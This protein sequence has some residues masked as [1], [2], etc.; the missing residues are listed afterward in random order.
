MSTKTVINFNSGPSKLPTP[1][2]ELI[3]QDNHSILEMSHRSKE[4]EALCRGVEKT[5]MRLLE[6]P[7]G[8]R[9]LLLQGGGCGQFAAVP[10]NLG[11]GDYLVTGYWSEKAHQEA[12]LLGRQARMAFFGRPCVQVPR[13]DEIVWD[14]NADYRY[15]CSNET[16]SG[17]QYPSNLLR[18]LSKVVDVP[19]V[20]DA[21]SDLLTRRLPIAE[22]A[23]VFAGA[24]KNLGIA[25]LTV[26]VIRDD[27]LGRIKKGVP[28]VWDYQKQA[29]AKSLLNTPP[30]HAIWVMDKVLDW[31]ESQGGVTAMQTNAERRASLV[32][33]LIDGSDGFYRNKIR[34]RSKVNITFNIRDSAL[35]KTFLQSAEARGF[36]GLEGHRSVGGL[37]ASLYNAIS[38]SETETLVEFM[39][40]FR[41]E[42]N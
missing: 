33:Q 20:I 24:Q 18:D 3:R 10:L 39:E 22:S 29:E 42:N 30:T 28:S 13:V 14:L 11:K 34:D 2:M 5:L 40:K 6:I 4:F 7:D 9:T 31:I 26:V 27:L 35:E 36:S 25:G 38:D 21:S 15:L 32:Y 1:V 23:M 19:L 37:R 17:L 12:L 16:I 41:Q 8:F